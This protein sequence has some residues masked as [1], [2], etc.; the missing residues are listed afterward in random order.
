VNKNT[1]VT[2]YRTSFIH[3]NCLILSVDG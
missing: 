3:S 1:K 2:Q